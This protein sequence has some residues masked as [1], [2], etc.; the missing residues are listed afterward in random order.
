MSRSAERRALHALA[1]ILSLALLVGLA[2]CAPS[3]DG[4]ADDAEGGD[5]TSSGDAPQVAEFTALD[6]SYEG[7]ETLPAGMTEM[8]L[9]NEGAELHQIQLVRLGEDKTVEDL[10]ADLTEAGGESFPDY[11]TLLGGPNGAMPGDTVNAYVDLTEGAYAILDAIPSPSG[12]LHV[13]QGMIAGLPV[14]AAE[15]PSADAPEADVTVHAMDFAFELPEDIEAGTHTFSFVNDGSEPHEIVVVRLDE[16]ATAMDIAA[17]FAPDAPPEPPPGWV[18]GGTVGIE[19]AAEQRF[20]V[21]L[22]SGERY[23]LICFLP[24]AEDGTPHVMLGMHSEFAIP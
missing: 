19:P 14:T 6:H 22:E 13:A 16:G 8:R 4:D 12:E 10:A 2:A 11:A 18:V 1:A 20:D 5:T 23:A 17:A 7:P 9:S 15:G 21:T 24:A 3:G